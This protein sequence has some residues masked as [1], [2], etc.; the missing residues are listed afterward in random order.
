MFFLTL[1]AIVSAVQIGAVQHPSY[2]VGGSIVRTNELPFAVHLLADNSPRCGAAIL[3][4]NWIVTA[5]HCITKN[6]ALITSKLT[7]TVGSAGEGK[8]YQIKSMVYHPDYDSTSF[9]NDI[10]IIR[11]ENSLPVNSKTQPI[12]ISL[13]TVEPNETLRAA[14]WG[15]TEMEVNSK[16]L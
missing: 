9:K 13:A 4:P 2:I 8:V 15:Q 5:A 10:A 7:V 11:M 16:Q 6:N 3:S 14:G 1:L 12:P